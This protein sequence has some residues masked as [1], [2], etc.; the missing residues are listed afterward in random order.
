MNMV[1]VFGAITEE[2]TSNE[3]Y[4]SKTFYYY[5]PHSLTFVSPSQSHNQNP[6]SDIYSWSD[7]CP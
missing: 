2:F 5:P 6:I 4:I 3:S 7:L 1:L